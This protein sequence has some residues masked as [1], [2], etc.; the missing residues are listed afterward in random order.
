MEIP[1]GAFTRTDRFGDTRDATFP[2]FYI[3]AVED[4]LASQRQGHPVYRD[5]ERVKIRIPGN[6]LSMPVERVT[7][8]A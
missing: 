8:S 7:L 3:E 4:P 1:T 2:E 6:N 5:E